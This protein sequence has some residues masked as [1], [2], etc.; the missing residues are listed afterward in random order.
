MA[1]R[2]LA[3]YLMDR[4]FAAYV[5]STFFALA[6]AGI[7]LL[8]SNASPVLGMVAIGLA[9]GAEVDMIGFF[10]SRYFGLKRFGQ[11]YG[12]LFSVFTVGAGLGPLLLGAAFTRFHSYEVGFIGCG[13]ALAMASICILAVGP[14]AYGSPRIASANAIRMRKAS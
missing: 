12:V 4:V 6:I 7:F 11:L 8:A 2:L 14:Y 5:A 10:V 9:A 13:L 3:G 1:G